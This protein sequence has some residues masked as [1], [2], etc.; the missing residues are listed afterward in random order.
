METIAWI[1][2]SQS[3]FAA[4]LIGTKHKISAPDRILTGWLCLMAIEFLTCALDYDLFKTPLLSNSF[5]LFNPAFFL[6]VRALIDRK[7]RLRWIHLLHLVPYIAFEM[8]AY[9]LQ[10]HQSLDS[11]IENDRN[12]VFRIIFAGVSFFSWLGY[13]LS[14]FVLVRRHRKDLKNEFSSIAN[15]FS[16]GWILFVVIFYTSFCVIAIG[17][18]LYVVMARSLINLPDP[19]IYS[20]WLLLVF[21]LGYYGLMQK[22]IYSRLIQEEPEVRYKKSYLTKD[23]KKKLRDRIIKHFEVDKPYL[24][25]ELS[26]DMLSIS[27]I[28]P[29]YQITEV[30]NMEIGKNFFQFVNEYRVNAVKQILADKNNPYSIEAIGYECGFN[31]KSSFFTVFKNITGQTPY[32]YRQSV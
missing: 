3:L 1:G 16:L 19:V 29:K 6:Y 5:L 28:A 21:I 14:S 25:P 12:L 2:L 9:I 17:M 15:T 32:Q 8:T 20:T 24:N 22:E 18:G 4:L 11:F 23:A 31:S 13:N 27:L 26:M 7:F 10:A 30:L